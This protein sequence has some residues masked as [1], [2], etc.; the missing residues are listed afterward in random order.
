MA[1]EGRIKLQDS[2]LVGKLNATE[3]GIVNVCCV[4]LISV[5]ASDN[6]AVN[7]SGVAMPGLK[8]DFADRIAGV[9]INE[10]NVECQRNARV[11]VSDVFTDILTRD[12]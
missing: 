6:A 7:T 10:L 9:D 1:G 12:P 4:G 2:I 8:R 5:S 3:H 11:T